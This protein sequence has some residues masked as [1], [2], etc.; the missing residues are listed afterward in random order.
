MGLFTPDEPN[1]NPEIRQDGFNRYKQCLSFYA[2]NWMKINL[3]TIM[4]ALPLATVIA[5]SILSSSVLILL[6]GSFLCGALFGPFLAGL[7]DAILRGLR[8]DPMNWKD[9]WRKSW[10]QNWRESLFPGALLGLLL[11]AYAFMAFLFWQAAVPPSA[12]TLALYAFAGFLLILFSTLYWPQMVLFQQTPANRIRNLILFSAKYLWRVAGVT[13]LQALYILL[14]ILF[15]PWTLL[16]LPFLG[17]WY[18]IFLAQFLIY[19]PLN[20][21]FQIEE[22]LF[23]T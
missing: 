14:Y 13:L 19:E 11:G 22:R 17:F 10:K 12:G 2:A 7:Y 1:Y 9:A 21:E 5:V 8:D 18:L 4:G 3:I 15:A 20:K 6:P 23:R 16:L